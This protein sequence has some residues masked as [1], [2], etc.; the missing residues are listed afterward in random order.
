MARLPRLLQCP[1]PQRRV[2]KNQKTAS[3]ATAC[4]ERVA[5]MQVVTR[6]AQTT[7]NPALTAREAK[8]VGLVVAVAAEMSVQ[9]ATPE[10][11]DLQ[12]LASA[13][14]L[15]EKPCRWTLPMQRPHKPTSMAMRPN[16]KTANGNPDKI[17]AHGPT[18]SAPSAVDAAVVLIERTLNALANEEPSAM[19]RA[20]KAGM[21]LAMTAATRPCQ[22]KRERVG[23]VV[24]KAVAKVA[25][26]AVASAALT[27]MHGQRPTRM[28]TA[29]RKMRPKAKA[30]IKP[31]RQTPTAR[32]MA[33]ATMDRLVRHAHATV[34]DVSA[35]PAM[36]AATAM[37]APTAQ[38]VLSAKTQYR[39]TDSKPWRAFQLARQSKQLRVRVKSQCGRRT[40]RKLSLQ[41]RP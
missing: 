13:W 14:M 26:K 6:V 35:V 19:S 25:G 41:V 9:I 22:L 37:S 1:H 23:T 32:P 39:V 12:R 34:T 3:P 31:T 2:K 10:A 11:T 16:R 29:H 27:E 40:S 7:A 20:M 15:M 30:V 8:V 33:L 4:A 18:A 36:T 5:V 17:A 24:T 21:K 28:T 38:S